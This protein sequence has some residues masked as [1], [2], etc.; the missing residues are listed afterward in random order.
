MVWLE[1]LRPMIW[2]L[3]A[4]LGTGRVMEGKELGG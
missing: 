3:K 1:S 4:R 2:G